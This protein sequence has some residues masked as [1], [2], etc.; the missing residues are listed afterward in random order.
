MKK[1][2]A[3]AKTI[4][5]YLATLRTDQRAALEKLRQAI[6]VAAPKAEECI[7]YGIPGFRLHRRLLVSFGAAKNHCAFY[8]GSHPIRAHKRELKEYGT[9]K[10][11]IRFP[12]EQPLPA[13]LVRKLVRSR[14]KEHA[15]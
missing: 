15:A 2:D 12:A 6:R 4:D 1:R 3:K 5:E 10:G 8:P 11:T 13:H 14:I 9:A 7:S